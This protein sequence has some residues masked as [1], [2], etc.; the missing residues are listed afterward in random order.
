MG[1]DSQELHNHRC[2]FP[3]SGRDEKLHACA[4]LL[5]LTMLISGLSNLCHYAGSGPLPSRLKRNC[6]V[7]CSKDAASS[8]H[9]K[10]RHQHTKSFLL[11]HV[12][13]NNNPGV[14][15][16]QW[17]SL[18]SELQI[19]GLR[20]CLNSHFQ[21]WNN[22]LSLKHKTKHQTQKGNKGSLVAA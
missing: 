3:E 19:S 12:E 16:S 5:S 22:K 6:K 18:Q 10:K 1:V 9:S 21:P 14:N 7:S 13:C 11:L 17:I 4:H 8:P 20:K 2:C 15:I